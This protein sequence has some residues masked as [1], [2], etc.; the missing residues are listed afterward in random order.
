[1]QLDDES[2]KL[3]TF[4]IP[5]GRFRWLRMPFGIAPAPEEFQ[6][7]LNEALEGLD[8]VRTIADDI[9]VFGVG[10]TDDEAVVDHDRKLMALLQR[11]R[12]RHIKLNKDKMKFKLAQLSYVGHVISAEGLKP[13]P[14]KVEAIL[15]MPPPTDKQ[16]LRRIMGMVNYLQKFAPG[17][18]ELTTPIRILLKDDAEFVWEESVQGE[19][20][21]R[22]KAVIASAPVLKYFDPSVEAV[23]QCDA[24]QHGLGACL[25]QNGQP[26]AYASRS[27]T[28]TE[29]NYVQ[30]EKELL[31]IVFGVEKFESYL[32]GRKFKV[33][34]D[35]KPLDLIL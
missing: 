23:L 12:Q 19:C 3:T 34:T 24:S 14:A 5:W 1:M 13:D 8:G 17:L 20:F 2:S 29:C 4:A 28:E 31:A 27:L 30:M 16:G 7:R 25:M 18:S 15:N 9:I 21:K 32:Y 26:V 10:D 33:E 35:Y 22:V 11:C 6:R